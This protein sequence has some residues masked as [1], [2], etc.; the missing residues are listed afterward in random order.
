MT[1]YEELLEDSH[2]CREYDD[3]YGI[4]TWCGSIIPGSFSD[5]ELHGYDPSDAV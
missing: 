4:C 3:G 2:D 5:Y 1:E